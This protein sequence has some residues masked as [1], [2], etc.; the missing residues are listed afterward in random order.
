VPLNDS[1][2]VDTDEAIGTNPAAGFMG[3]NGWGAIGVVDRLM[4][5]GVWFGLSFGE[6][7]VDFPEF[8]EAGLAMLFNHGLLVLEPVGVALR[9][10]QDE[11]DDAVGDGGP[12]EYHVCSSCRL[13]MDTVCCRLYC[14][15]VYSDAGVRQGEPEVCCMAAR[16]E[17]GQTNERNRINDR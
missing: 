12:R 13:T 4:C 15:L 7:E 3:L 5:C 14:G 1:P 11:T 6:E 9:L 10:V 2:D 8:V 17:A 16:L